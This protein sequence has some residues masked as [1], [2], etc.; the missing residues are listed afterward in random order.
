MRALL[1]VLLMLACCQAALAQRLRAL[2]DSELAGVSGGDGISF[3]VH[4]ELNQPAANGRLR[5]SRLTLGQTVDGRTT[6]TVIR[7]PGGVIDMLGLNLAAHTP[8][9]GPAYVALT[10]PAY[11]HFTDVGFD[12]LSVQADPRGAVTDSLGR[13]TLNGTLSMQGQ[14]RMWAH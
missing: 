11:V 9:D 6:Y 8:S 7:N 5:E 13:F 12:S 3:A 4:L 2:A 14:L 1:A 10:L